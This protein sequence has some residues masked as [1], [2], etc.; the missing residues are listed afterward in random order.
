M[1]RVTV[2]HQWW[3]RPLSIALINQGQQEHPSTNEQPLSS[4]KN[5]TSKLGVL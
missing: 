1:L 4:G 5:A 3:P 2:A